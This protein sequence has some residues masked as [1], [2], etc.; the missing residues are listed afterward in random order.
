MNA[1]NFASFFIAHLKEKPK[2]HPAY[3][4]V[5]EKSEDELCKRLGLE[6]E[7]SSKITDA[8]FPYFASVMLPDCAYSELEVCSKW[9]IW[10]FLLDDE[11]DNGSLRDDAD[12]AEVR[13]NKL[14]ATME[15][16][17]FHHG[18]DEMICIHLE[19]WRA[20]KQKK[21][22]ARGGASV[23]SRYRDAMYGYCDG[24][25]QHVRSSSTQ[26]V[27]TPEEYLEARKLSSGCEPLYA[28]VEY[29]YGLELSDEQ[30]CEPSILKL[31]VASTRMALLHN[32][33][34]SWQK[35]KNENVPHNY[36][37]TVIKHKGLS[38]T[39]AL[40]IMLDMVAGEHKQ[41]SDSLEKLATEIP[42]KHHK[43]Y[44]EGILRV[45]LANLYWRKLIS[46]IASKTQSLAQDRST[47]RNA[48]LLRWLDQADKQDGPVFNVF[49]T[50]I[51]KGARSSPDVNECTLNLNG[52]DYLE[53]RY[54]VEPREKWLSMAKYRKFTIGNLTLSCGDCV[55]VKPR[56]DSG[57]DW[58]AQVHEVRAAD[59]HHVF[60]RCS[61]LENP[62]E[63]PEDVRSTSSYHG[64]FELVPSNKMDIIDALTV[65]GPLAVAYW[66]EANDDANMP[67]HGEYYWR[68]TYH[69]DTR[70]LSS[71]NSICECRQPQN[72]DRL[73]IKCSNQTCG[74][75][76]HASCLAQDAVQRRIQQKGV[77]AEV[78]GREQAQKSVHKHHTQSDDDVAAEDNITVAR[79]VA[80][81][82][83]ALKVVITDKNTGDQTEEACYDVV[84]D[85]I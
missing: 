52:K 33:M 41:L 48:E 24:V 29:A 68:Q 12:A 63:L 45:P 38:E 7:T 40:A 72:P 31:R 46:K 6:A 62:E 84:D 19:I 54:I 79:I 53:A 70:I 15:D 11:F 22:S 25:L 21:E 9:M 28:L 80:L 49:N 23:Q 64:K 77:K 56:D 18:A 47:A 34:I 2:V 66:E 1:A 32:D 20:T 74:I 36:I 69:H 27:P 58:K 61:W 57:R 42:T 78:D 82:A 75:W 37:N 39:D 43:M 76:L 60:L 26:E 14:R 30:V 44:V 17:A 73:V 83:E 35:E 71:L 55:F 3:Q 13:L 50:P 4:V 81:E 5:K 59:E 51:R 67:A 8:A 10:I 65:N 85:K 16:D